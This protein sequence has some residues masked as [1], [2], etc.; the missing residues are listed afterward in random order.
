MRPMRPFSFSLVSINDPCK[1]FSGEERNRHIDCNSAV[2]SA[3]LCARIRIGKGKHW[4]LPRVIV[5]MEM[6]GLE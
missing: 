3:G 5:E 4:L 6:R 2:V 1:V